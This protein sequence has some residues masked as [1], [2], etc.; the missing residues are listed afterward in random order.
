MFITEWYPTAAQPVAGIFVREHAKSVAI[1][2]DVVVLH[3]M[4][5]DPALPEARRLVRDTDEMLTAGLS[6]YRLQRRP[7]RMPGFSSVGYIQGVVA[8][9][10]QL[11]ANGFR[12]DIIH[13]HIYEAG[14]P[15]VI[16]GAREHIP[17]VITEH[18][19]AFFRHQLP[20]WQLWKARFAFERAN[21]VLPVSRALQNDIEAYDI[22]ARF[23]IVPNAV[24]TTL[25]HPPVQPARAPG[26]LRLLFVGT[27]IPLK[28]LDY[29][30]RALAQM[31]R[32]REEWQ[33][34]VIGD[35]PQRTAYELLAGELSVAQHVTFHG[36]KSKLEV[37]ELM[38]RADLFVLA[39]LHETFSVVCV[40]A[41]ASGL[42]VVA[43]RCGGPEDFVD[44]TVGRLVPP[45]DSEALARTLS[46]MLED[47]PRFVPARLAQYAA[48]R[49]SYERIGLQLDSIY[50]EM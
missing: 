10:R 27:L 22:R 16:F 24:D 8:S 50:R 43:T 12:P 3:P 15:A 21:R 38:R 1:Y 28:G 14:M 26:P 45:G 5:K 29:L 37:A 18:A 11:M 34:D 32:R 31:Q 36:F 23:T 49:F 30:L 25:F 13:A 42:P 35:G 40:E 39:S 41:L 17:V 2:D 33:L 19:S 7:A 9:A 20:P 4:A 44:E 48:E 6:T 47:L 46:E